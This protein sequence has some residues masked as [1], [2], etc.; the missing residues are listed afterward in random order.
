MSSI[1]IYQPNEPLGK[2]GGMERATH[3]LACLL[4]DEG[5]RIML[6]CREKNR[7][8]EHYETP[9]PLTFIPPNLNKE[10]EGKFV[11]NL[12]SRENAKV[13]IDQTE[14]GI[15]GRW[16]IFSTRRE[17][18]SSSL[19]LIAVQHSSQYS[20][21]KYYRL[22]QKKS[23]SGSF[24]GRIKSMIYH[25]LYLGMK[26]CRAQLLQKT[27]F[28]NLISNYDRIVTLSKGAVTEFRLLCPQASASQFAVIPNSITLLP[29]HKPIQKERRC[30]FVGRLDNKAKGIDRLLR[31]W[32]SVEEK[33]SNWHLD[34]VGDGQDAAW[35]Q[36]MARNLRLNNVSF[37][38]FQ[39][40][41]SYYDRS[42]LFCMTST[43]EGFGMVLI[44]AMQHG[45]IPIAFDSYPAVRDIIIPGKTGE[46]IQPFDES[47]YINKIIALFE[48]QERLSSMAENA[49]HHVSR[50][51]DKTVATA[52]NHVIQDL[53]KE[54]N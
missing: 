11:N 32:K 41:K 26:K 13:I 45:C 14:G 3:Q 47:E 53:V 23:F 6:L 38:G 19:K 43:F 52:W 16:G 54:K 21:L 37:E 10:E 46:L 5:H 30:L 24:T 17:I 15:I 18:Q 4:R 12:I 2:Q 44:E 51:S 25:G 50:F 7:L 48:N 33:N 27:L 42:S 31:I 40:P 29:Q 22:I 39:Q 34:I 8:G 1:I 49:V 35:L 36:D 9:V 20:Y 28:Q